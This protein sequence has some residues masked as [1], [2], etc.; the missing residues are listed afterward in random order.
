M[1]FFC[2]GIIFYFSLLHAGISNRA[3]FIAF[4]GLVSSDSDNSVPLLIC[5]LLVPGI[6]KRAGLLGD[7][8]LSVPFLSFDFL[9][10]RIKEG[11][12]LNTS[13]RASARRIDRMVKRGGFLTSDLASLW[14]TFLVFDPTDVSNR[15]AS[16]APVSVGFVGGW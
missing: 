11:S 2:A 10:I 6:A 3:L 15:A 1:A 14:L 7:C 8:S 16:L 9:E 4:F 5:F 12:L 13:S